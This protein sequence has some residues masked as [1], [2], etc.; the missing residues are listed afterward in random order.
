M[1]RKSKENLLVLKLEHPL[2]EESLVK[3]IDFPSDYILRKRLALNEDEVATIRQAYG[4]FQDTVREVL[5][6]RVDRL[7]GRRALC[8]PD[9]VPSE[10]ADLFADY[11]AEIMVDEYQDSNLV[12]EAILDSNTEEEF[13]QEHKRAMEVLEEFKALE[14]SLDLQ[15]EKIDAK[16]VKFFKKKNGDAHKRRRRRSSLEA[17]WGMFDFSIEEFF[18]D[19]FCQEEDIF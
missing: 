17:E 19:P 4:Y 18:D 10:T 9:G 2:Y 7:R 14:R 3:Y 16:T 1:S 13:R 8:W 6:A 12:Q 11:F 5:Q 15:M